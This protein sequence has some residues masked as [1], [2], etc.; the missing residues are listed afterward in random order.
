MTDL[1]WEVRERR[2]KSQI[3]CLVFS[4]SNW[5]DSGDTRKDERQ[6][7]GSAGKAGSREGMQEARRSGTDDM[8]QGTFFFFFLINFSISIIYYFLIVVD[9]HCF[10]YIAK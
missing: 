2:R 10:G 6:D 1:S 3:W 4:L 8:I 7:L 5:L 9:L